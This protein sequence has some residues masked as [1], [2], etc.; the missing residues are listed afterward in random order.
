MTIGSPKWKSSTC[1][2]LLLMLMHGFE[3]TT[4]LDQVSYTNGDIWRHPDLAKCLS[5]VFPNTRL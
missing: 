5:G 4:R 3:Q 2:F 1:Y